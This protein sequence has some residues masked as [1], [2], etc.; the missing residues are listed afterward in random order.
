MLWKGLPSQS[1][2]RIRDF[3]ECKGQRKTRVAFVNRFETEEGGG[4]KLSINGGRNK[5]INRQRS[6][7]HHEKIRS[8]TIGCDPVLKRRRAFTSSDTPTPLTAALLFFFPSR[9]CT[10]DNENPKIASRE[11]DFIGKFQQIL[12]PFSSARPRWER[13]RGRERERERET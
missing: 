4:W 2:P 12:S 10:T 8:F 3:R 6:Y 13:G 11:I 1:R 7:R 5:R 9:S